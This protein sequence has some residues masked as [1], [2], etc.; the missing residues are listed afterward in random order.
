MG[1]RCWE[2]VN[3][4]I[5]EAICWLMCLIPDIYPRPSHAKVAFRGTKSPLMQFE[6][7]G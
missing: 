5:S 6:M 3:V 7:E 2:L 4:M 1:P